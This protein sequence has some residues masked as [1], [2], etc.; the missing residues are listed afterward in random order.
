MSWYSDYLYRAKIPCSRASGSES[1]YQMR[2]QLVKGSGVNSAG[3]IYLNNRCLNWPNDIRF[4]KAD[5]VSLLD[6]YR[7]EYDATDGTWWI[8]FTYIDVDDTDFYVYYGKSGAASASSGANTFIFFDDFETGNF[9]RWSSAG[10]AWSVQSLVKAEGS[11][12]AKGLYNTVR[13]LYVLISPGRS[14]SIRSK[15][16]YT[17]ASA[18]SEGVH[19]YINAATAGLGGIGFNSGYFRQDTGAAYTD[20]PVPTSYSINT[21]YTTECVFDFVNVKWRVAIN[22]VDKDGGAPR[23]MVTEAGGA[24]NTTDQISH[25]KC[26]APGSGLGTVYIDQVFMRAYSYPEPTWSVPGVEEEWTAIVRGLSSSRVNSSSRLSRLLPTWTM[27]P[28]VLT[29]PTYDGSGQAVHPSAVYIPG[30]FAG[31]KYWM[32][33]TP[34][35][36]GNDTYENPSIIA[37]ND[38]ITW[39]VP[40]GVT[41]PLATCPPSGH[42]SDSCLVWDSVNRKLYYYYL[43]K[44][45]DLT[46][47]VYRFTITEGPLA[48]SARSLSFTSADYLFSPAIVLNGASDWVM[49][50]FG[51]SNI[52]YKYVSTDGMTWTGGNVVG[53]YSNGLHVESIITPWH[54]SMFKYGSKYVCLLTAPPYGSSSAYTDLYWG[55]LNDVDSPMDV[56]LTPL[57]TQFAGWG[58]RQVYLCS[59]VCM[60]NGTYRVYISAA[61]AANVWTIGYADISLC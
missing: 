43:E 4:T 51:G 31:Y 50:I 12:A 44:L 52:L 7:E 48:I 34:Y 36:G 14:V 17:H 45:S 5:G 58:S 23:T 10:N 47:N 28:T 46:H 2:I 55:I 26:S 37:S 35:P 41:N 42:N 3:V 61:T 18:T 22:D 6:H 21:W 1:N 60:E 57:L 20:I 27:S 8:E 13:S 54:F 39:V 9:S 16:Q 24:V 32:G 29:I 40:A 25:I 33:M 38:G 19:A 15:I 11:Y 49:W 30:G 56:N 59:L 53:I